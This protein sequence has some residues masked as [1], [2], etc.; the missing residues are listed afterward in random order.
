M[1]AGI[2]GMMH[3]IRTWIR[4]RIARANRRLLIAM[5]CYFVLIGVALYA[6]LPIRTKDDGFLLIIVL[7]IFTFLIVKTLDHADDE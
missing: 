2:Y 6:L 7:C 5:A 1:R 4:E 3:L